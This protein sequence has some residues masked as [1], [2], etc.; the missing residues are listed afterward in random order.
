[1][2][3]VPFEVLIDA[4]HRR[5]IVGGE[6]LIFHCHHYNTYL[7]RTLDEDA[8]DL[9]MRPVL[10]GA[11]AEVAFHQ[12]SRLFADGDVRALPERVALA[13][14]LYR[15]QGFGT[16]ELGALRPD[17]P[18]VIE[19]ARS[20]YELGWRVKFGP[21]RGPV[22]HFSAGWLA[23][24]AA[25]LFD[26]PLG[27]YDVRQT[28]GTASGAATCRFEVV[29]VPAGAQP[30]FQRFESVGVGRL[31]AHR[32]R[33]VPATPVHYD[34][35]FEAVGRM[36]LV[37]DADGNLAAFGVYLTRHFANYYC[38]IS[39]ELV[40]ALSARFGEEGRMAAEP[41]LIEAGHVCAFNTFGGIMTSTEWDALIRPALQTR[42]DW[43]HGIVAV[44]NTLGWGRWQVTDVSPERAEFVLH[45]DYEG[46]AWEA[47]YGQASHPVE[48]LARGGVAG[49]MN[50]VFYGDIRQRPELTEDYYRELFRG[51]GGFVA[52]PTASRACGDEVTAFRVERHG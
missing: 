21:A 1:M 39:F 2:S 45:D 11:A 35:I 37:G 36:P 26:R 8:A 22:S 13:E 7:Q 31:T 9:D 24:A 38:R 41:L 17:A 52:T 51:Q 3:S 40:R 15:W 19:T 6:P 14:A 43:V 46:V 4:E 10:V 32:L 25:A 28:A 23:G 12:L 44:V 49:L 18:S 16:L 30:S 5:C 42:E 47:M 34:A 29:L 33:P 50:L 27:T 48:Y 20:H